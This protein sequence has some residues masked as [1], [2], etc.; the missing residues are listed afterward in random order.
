MEIV[1]LLGGWHFGRFRR[2]GFVSPPRVLF[3]LLLLL[4]VFLS[5]SHR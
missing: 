5:V 1:V 2:A 4:F 3:S